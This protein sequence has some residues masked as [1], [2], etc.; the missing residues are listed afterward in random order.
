MTKNK[1]NISV[2]PLLILVALILGAG[3]LL[4][5][6]EIEL[7]SFTEERTERSKIEGY[8]LVYETERQIEKSRSVIKSEEELTAFLRNI[9]P[10]GILEVRRNIDWGNEYVLGVSS[11][12]FAEFNHKYKIHKLEE[13]TEEEAL[14]VII[15]RTDPGDSC[16]LEPGNNV[17]VDF[18]VISATDWNISFEEYENTR[19]C[20]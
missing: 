18:A 8:P 10:D 16:E 3:Y 15:R 19:E 6:D 2:L 9:D 14:K 11:K 4:T 20:I 1:L 5:K 17:I 12:T 7:P 13:N